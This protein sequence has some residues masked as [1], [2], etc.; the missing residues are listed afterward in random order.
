MPLTKQKETFKRKGNTER[1][2][3]DQDRTFQAKKFDSR[4][5][6]IGQQIMR[7]L[8]FKY[9]KTNSHGGHHLGLMWRHT[10]LIKYA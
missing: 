4:L 5:I 3:V 7:L 8:E 2:Y 1:Q 6:K 10:A 9:L